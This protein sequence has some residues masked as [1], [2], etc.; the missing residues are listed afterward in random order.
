MDSVRSSLP[1]ERL[2]AF[3]RQHQG[4]ACALVAEGGVICDISRNAFAARGLAQSVSLGDIVTV[5]CGADSVRGEV[6]QI[7]EEQVRIKP[8]DETVKPVLGAS[9]FAHGAFAVRPDRSWRGR[10]VNA[11]G[12][13]IDEEGALVEGVRPMAIE[14]VALPALQRGR[15]G[16]PLRTGVKVLDIFTPL[17]FGQRIGVF[18]GSGV[19]KSTLLAMMTQADHFDT[20]VLA[21][22]GERGR[23]VRDMLED[24]LAGKRGKVV[25]V[26]ATGDESPMM[27]RMAPATATTI[28]EY[29]A[30]LGDNVLLMV[31]SVTR[32]ALAGREVG[33]AAGEPPVSRG[34]PPGVFSQLARLLERAGP[35]REGRGSI[36]G[37]YAVLIDGDDHNDPVAD[38]IRGILDGHIVLDRAIV[39]Q[40]RF[41]AVDILASI[42]RLAAHCWTAEQRQLVKS[43]R[44]MVARYEE[45]RDL[46]AMGAYKAGSDSVLDQ[47]VQLVP[48]LYAAM[49]QG[50]D[51]PPVADAYA[52]LARALRDSAGE[53]AKA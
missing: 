48:R 43:L 8:F 32:Y 14:A 21:L 28:A 19:G 13:A 53:G 1:L 29:F 22:T 5:D 37:V 39:A 45:T 31:D 6:I 15:V 35:G 47:A 42:S 12:E 50:P 51:T 23:E 44:E 40:G 33:I 9:V 38:A 18:A 17:C 46:R 52:E 10:V 3:A 27:R 36:T 4:R 16:T 30:G 11:L 24:T 49:A 34:F 7:S 2:A 20:V 41:P 25:A 26:V